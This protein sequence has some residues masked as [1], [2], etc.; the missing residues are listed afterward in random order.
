MSRSRYGSTS[1]AQA[2][3][4][5][6][7][8]AQAPV[9]LA[10]VASVALLLVACAGDSDVNDAF[11][12]ERHDVD[13]VELALEVCADGEVLE[14]IDV[15]YYQGQPDWEAVAN[16]GIQYAITRVN[17]GGFMDPEFDTN[18]DAIKSVGL[19]RGAY[20]Y[21]NAG[22]D[23]VE[24]A[25]VFIDKV[26]QLGPGDLP[27]VID[28]ESD[29]G[30]DP[31]AIA[32]S[33]ATWV[34]LVEAGTGRKPIVYTGPYFWNTFVQ[35]D[36]FQEHPL[37]IA[38]YTNGCPSVPD[39]WNGWRLW[40]Y[41]ST[42][43]IAGISG[44]VDTNRFNGSL[45]QLHD[46]A[47]NGLRAEIVSLD[48]PEA[49]QVGE[50]G[51]VAVELKNVGAR[52]WGT[53]TMLGTTEPRDRDSDFVSN[54]W[55]TNQ[56]AAAFDVEIASG[57]TV[58]LSFEITANAAG[59]FSEHFNLVEEG[60]AWFSDIDPGGGPADD[61]IALEI[62]VAPSS[63]ASAGVGGG[64]SEGSGE[65]GGETLARGIPNTGGNSS[66]NYGGTSDGKYG[67]LLL[68]FLL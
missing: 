68:S 67:W 26:G 64:S 55:L 66:C 4:A 34:E 41:S 39:A 65:G 37:W 54:N 57:E 22:G 63:S 31:S 38:H 49:M 45:E 25:N 9:V 2:P 21:F 19:V 7:P 50:T 27:G 5:Q 47:A 48:Y 24:Q 28:V 56:R 15:S 23:P 3:V 12:E 16:D 30:L 52:T 14:G 40:Q 51:T 18:W 8:V 61:A 29:D 60:V 11:S 6:A 43:A 32:E 62:T 35:T 10:P 36:Q 59:T 13:Q 53:N 1:L 20:Q 33:V 42:G 17:H 58:I 44:N 46:F